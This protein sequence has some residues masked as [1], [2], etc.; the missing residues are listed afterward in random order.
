MNCDEKKT[1]SS[2]ETNKCS[3]FWRDPLEWIRN[4]SESMQ[5]INHADPPISQLT[6]MIK[7]QFW[8]KGSLLKPQFQ[9]CF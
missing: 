9:V 5:E 7:Q 3:K 6:V 1:E 8:T 4:I 2:I